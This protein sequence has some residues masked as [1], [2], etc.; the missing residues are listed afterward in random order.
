MEDIQ[1]NRI[2]SFREVTYHRDI[3]RFP[4]IPESA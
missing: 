3:Q 1:E 4:Q 2:I